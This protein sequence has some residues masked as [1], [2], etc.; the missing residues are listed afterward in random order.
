MAGS[1]TPPRDPREELGVAVVGHSTTSNQLPLR[2]S[3]SRA[4]GQ[5]KTTWMTSGVT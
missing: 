3:P 1:L 2:E 5:S 4:S